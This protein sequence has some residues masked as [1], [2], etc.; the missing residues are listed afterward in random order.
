[1]RS[2]VSFSELTEKECTRTRPP[3]DL[4]DVQVTDWCRRCGCELYTQREISRRLC[5]DCSA[6]KERLELFSLKSKRNGLRELRHIRNERAGL[7]FGA[8]LPEGDKVEIPP[9]Q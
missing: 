6:Q 2:A 4:Q 3:G 7:F 8:V 5:T 9:I 1:M